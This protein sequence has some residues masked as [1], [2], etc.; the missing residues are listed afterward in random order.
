[1]GNAYRS[2]L[3]LKPTGDAVPAN[4]LAGKTFS[5]AAGVGKT[6]TMINNGAVSVT[7]TD[8]DPTYTI[9]EGYHN[10]L[11]VVGFSASGGDGADL[12]V[13][14]SDVFAG[15]T[16]SCT[17]GTTTYTETC[18]SSSPYEVTFQSIPVGTWTIS[19]SYSGTTFSTIFTVL[20]FEAALNAIPEGSTATPT[21]D[22]QTWL[23]CAEIFDKNYTTISQVLA[24]AST[25]Q[26]LIASNNAVDYMARSTT[27]ASS[28]VSDSSAMTY[29]GLND[30]CSDALLADSTWLTAICGSTYFESVLN[31]KNPT[32]T[33]D[34]T[35]SG[36]C[37]GS[38]LF[39]TSY[40]YWY[41]FDNNASHAWYPTYATGGSQAGQ[42]CGYKFTN[43]TKAHYIKL[44]YK[45]RASDSVI[46]F[47]GSNDGSTYI[48]LRE[49]T[50]SN[51]GNTDTY[52]DGSWT[53]TNDNA[54]E[55]YRVYIVSGTGGTSGQGFGLN[56][57]DI[58][59]RS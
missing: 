16:I 40:K 11:G 58:Y 54:Y 39:S 53:I 7:L 46:K 43:Q 28:V 23:H 31:V 35:P 52:V 38:S 6:G 59:C 8:Q 20:D 4:V 45:S 1:M 9:P 51:T 14:C 22:I 44:K 18:P 34:T 17:D 5:N 42:Y 27:W 29:I 10:G 13:T 47:Q 12:I 36:N 50:V 24:D 57:M 49:I 55:Y 48:D 32:M 41:A 25:L 2:V 3:A 15:A 21:D 37:F 26:A 30:Y 56:Q 33:S 19:G